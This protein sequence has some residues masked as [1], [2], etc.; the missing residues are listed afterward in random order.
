M[1][2]PFLYRNETVSTNASRMRN[3]VRA[4]FILQIRKMQM[5]S[6]AGR[7]TYVFTRLNS[8]RRLRSG[9]DEEREHVSFLDV[10]Y[11]QLCMSVMYVFTLTMFFFLYHPPRRTR[12]EH[13]FSHTTSATLHYAAV[14]ACVTLRSSPCVR[15][16]APAAT[17]APISTSRWPRNGKTPVDGLNGR[18]LGI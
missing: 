1:S 15:S 2:L 6:V 17:T 4:N 9:R 18:C 11:V 13:Y 12:W 14:R 3:A 8:S 10:I 5:W 7:R 16:S